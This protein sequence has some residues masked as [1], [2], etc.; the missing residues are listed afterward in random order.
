MSHSFLQAYT[1]LGLLADGARVRYA[2]GSFTSDLT[3]DTDGLVI[4]Y[5]TMAHRIPPPWSSPTR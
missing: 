1:H 4:D 5:P 2:S 3:V